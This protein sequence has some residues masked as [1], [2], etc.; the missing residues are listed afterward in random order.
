MV[1]LGSPLPKFTYG[2]TINMEYKGFDLSAFFYGSYGNKILNG[3]KQYMY[4]FQQNSNHAKEF[5][6][7]YVQNDIIKLDENGNPKVVVKQNI[8][9][10]IA[11]NS[12]SR[13][14]KCWKI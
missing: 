2:L 14:T 7:R 5:A 10:D 9:T 12:N 6:D 3:T 13:K 11:R 1:N 4:W 8:D